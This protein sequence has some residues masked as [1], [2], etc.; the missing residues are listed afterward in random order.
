MEGPEVFKHAVRNLATVIGEAVEAA[1]LV[2][3]NIDWLV[4]HQ[5]NQRIL[6]TTAKKVE[7]GRRQNCDDG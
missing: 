6:S 3:A 7:N 2:P 4:P 1:G 5:A